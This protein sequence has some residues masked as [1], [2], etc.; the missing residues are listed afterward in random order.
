MCNYGLYASLHYRRA[1]LACIRH[2]GDIAKIINSKWSQFKVNP[3]NATC[4]EL[5]CCKGPAPH[6]SNSPFLMFDIWALW[7][8]N[9]I[10]GERVNWVYVCDNRVSVQKQIHKQSL[11]RLRMAKT[12][13]VV[14]IRLTMAKTVCVCRRPLN[15]L[16]HGDPWRIRLN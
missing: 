16:L 13:K 14:L 5:L 7:C 11:R 6:W 4:S 3:F 12:Q 9:E 8:L 10:G 2:C 1:F 15:C